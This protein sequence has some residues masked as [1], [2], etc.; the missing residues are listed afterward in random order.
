MFG[1]CIWLSCSY[2]HFGLNA[3]YVWQPLHLHLPSIDQLNI[4][5]IHI[6]ISKCINSDHILFKI[7]VPNITLISLFIWQKRNREKK[8][9]KHW[10]GLHPPSVATFGTNKLFQY[11]KI[12]VNRVDG[13]SHI[14][15]RKLFVRNLFPKFSCWHKRQR[16]SKCTHFS[17][18]FVFDS[19]Y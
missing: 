9:S 8:M 1:T 2:L 14:A 5:H 12:G 6:C 16:W 19:F 11:L 4:T 10:N 17:H 15:E 13:Y 7:H 3:A 18:N